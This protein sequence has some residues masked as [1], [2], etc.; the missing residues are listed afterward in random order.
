LGNSFSVDANL[1]KKINLFLY[2]AKVEIVKSSK[3]LEELG[4]KSIYEL[5]GGLL[6]WGSS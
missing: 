4:F 3:K 5:D 1:D 2:I 6:K